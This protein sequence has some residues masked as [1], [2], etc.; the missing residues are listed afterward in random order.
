MYD[1][2]YRESRRRVIDLLAPLTAAELEVTVPA[3]PR[4]TIADLL[5]HFAGASASFT[6]GTTEG[7]PGSEEWTR[8]QIETRRGRSRE[9]LLDEWNRHAPL[10]EQLPLSSRS[11]LPV[12]HDTLSHEADLRG[13]I[14][15]PQLPG[16]ALTAAFEMLVPILAV[17]LGP[18]GSVV[19]DLDEQRIE[20]GSGSPE[21]Y[22]EASRYE[23]WRGYF[24]RRSAQQLS[25]WVRTGDATAFAQ[26]LPV[27]PARDT[28]LTEPG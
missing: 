26:S 6:E 15:A 25:G 10:V 16:D 14:G 3:C 5:A 7:R 27:F 4:W 24:G 19:L 28:D 22:I 9:Q 20:F 23:F 2:L 21:L 8:A 17:R 12:L 18:L 13:T 11:W 1:Q